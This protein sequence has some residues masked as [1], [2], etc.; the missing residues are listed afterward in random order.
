MK[1]TV[2]FF[3][4]GEDK[5]EIT[6]FLTFD[7]TDGWS[8][9]GVGGA[10]LKMIRDRQLSIRRQNLAEMNPHEALRALEAILDNP[11]NQATPVRSS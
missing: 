5:P 7:D 11:Y 6:G 10:I 1:S 9:E 2:Q 4:P 3:N 8:Q